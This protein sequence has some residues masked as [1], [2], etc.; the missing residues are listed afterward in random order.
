MAKGVT[1]KKKLNEIDG[2]LRDL[3]GR[4]P[5]REKE[6]VEKASPKSRV[7]NYRSFKKGEMKKAK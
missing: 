4:K 7:K 1:K 6:R 5:K 2:R 3:G